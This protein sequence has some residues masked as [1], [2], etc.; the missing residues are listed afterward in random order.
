MHVDAEELMPSGADRVIAVGTYRGTVRAS[1]E[2][3]EAAFAH[4]LTIRDGRIARL[5]QITDTVSWTP[6]TG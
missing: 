2:P 4:V 3:V 1:G 5:Q 6:A